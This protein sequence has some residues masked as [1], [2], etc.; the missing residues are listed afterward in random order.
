MDDLSE[1]QKWLQEFLEPKCQNKRDF[2]E[3][4]RLKKVR[5]MKAKGSIAWIC[6]KCIV[7]HHSEIDELK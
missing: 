3:Q 7:E 1:A 2:Y 5:F 4:F 6:D